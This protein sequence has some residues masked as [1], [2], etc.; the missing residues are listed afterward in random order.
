MALSLKKDR[1][2]SPC[3]VLI[4]SGV[5]TTG[6]NIT[7]ANVVIFAVCFFSHFMMFNSDS[8]S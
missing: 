8:D 2:G 4:I 7:A 1:H 3:D 6:L 5:G